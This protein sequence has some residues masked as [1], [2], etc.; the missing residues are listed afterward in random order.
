MMKVTQNFTPTG[1]FG[2][3]LFV[4]AGPIGGA[5]F[6]SADFYDRSNVTLIVAGFFA[7]LQLASLPMMLIGREYHS[8]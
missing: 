8:E 3:A 4:V 7:V 1:L 5:V 2:V 6:L